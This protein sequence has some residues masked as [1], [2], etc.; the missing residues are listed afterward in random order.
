MKEI[1]R[2]NAFTLVELLGVFTLIGVILLVVVPNVTQ[3]LT[4]S[5]G[6]DYERFLN[7]IYLATE[8]YIQGKGKEYST[9]DT[10]SGKAFV[11][12]RELVDN[13]Y[14]TSTKVNPQTNQKINLDA[15][16]VALKTPS[17]NIT[18]DFVNSDI[19]INAYKKTGLLLSYSIDSKPTT[20]WKDQ[21]GSELGND[22]QL[23]EFTANNGFQGNSVYL[24]G[25]NYIL[26]NVIN[27]VQVTL[28]T[29]I[30]I[31]EFSSA[32]QVLM[33]NYQN[34]GCGFTIDMDGNHK[35][36][37]A[38]HVN[39]TYH[40]IR[41]VQD[42]EVNR[43]YQLVGTYDGT[44]IKFY[45]DGVLQGTI[46]VTGTITVPQNST[47]F[48]IG[49]NPSGTVA[50]TKTKSYVSSVKIYN[51]ALTEQ[52]IMNDYQLDKARYSS[53]QENYVEGLLAQYDSYSKPMNNVWNDLTGNGKHATMSGFDN[54][55]SSG[56]NQF[57]LTLDGV[58]DYI[59][60]PNSITANKNY[61]IQ[62]VFQ[63]ETTTA[64]A[65]IMTFNRNDTTDIYNNNGRIELHSNLKEYFWYTDNGPIKSG[66][67]LFTMDNKIPASITLSVG[68]DKTTVYKNGEATYQASTKDYDNGQYVSINF[69]NRITSMYMNC[70]IYAIR[71]YNK[72]LTKEEVLKNYQLD[73]FRFGI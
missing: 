13:G 53:Q 72:A 30:M 47:H 22:G 61:T 28:S 55:V 50:A 48:M 5:K 43:Y 64:W 67:R 63:T 6:Q 16:V 46:A 40:L 34:G 52:E 33:G 25:T 56:W 12:V 70:S 14:L 18:Y 29:Y 54:T 36:T 1:K 38:V 19:T 15:T 35:I 42:Y 44:T 45:L 32:E 60:I 26:S 3:L 69:G 49:G 41:S 17:G 11:Q 51:H 59:Q 9:L 65:D 58:N 62:I 31:P 10:V 23:M 71:I 66:E 37:F 20:I 39:G 2:E 4:K 73:H 21:S 27:P 7:D 24:D 57:K 8:A 68:T